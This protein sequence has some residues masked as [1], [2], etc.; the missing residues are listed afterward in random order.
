VT[1]DAAGLGAGVYTGTL[2][3]LHNDPLTGQI[4]VAV[5][6]TVVTYEP[7]LSPTVDAASGDPET[8]VPY[9][10]T[11]TNDGTT[12][13]T[14]DLTVSGHAWTTT[15]PAS[16][17]PL[18]AGESEEV[19]VAVEIP[20][21]AHGGDQDVAT[22]SA[23]SR[24]DPKKSASAAL[25]TTV[26]EQPVV[27]VVAKTADP[28]DVVDPG[29]LITYTITVSN[30][31]H[32]RVVVDLSDQIPTYTTYVQGSVTGG[33]AY[34]EMPAQVAWNGTIDPGAERTCTFQVAVDEDAP[35]GGW[36]TNAVIALVDGEE[37]IE[38][39]EV[40]IRPFIY[41]PIVFSRA[42]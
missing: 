15:L 42:N 17:G 34:T 35:H 37:Y 3:L 4:D 23:T 29:D 38:Q 24:G 28:G 20:F 21:S 1:F 5:Q 14:F 36:I 2:R 10:L 33:L 22:V 7:V 13:D 41:L 26:A 12:T 9:T 31:G 32:D 18:A 16:V 30:D 6:M 39:V 19:T 11:L 40:R 8:T 25:T 27:L